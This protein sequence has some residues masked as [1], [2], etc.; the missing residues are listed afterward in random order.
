V[1]YSHTSRNAEAVGE[2]EAAFEEDRTN[3]ETQLLLGESLLRERR[4]QEA[5]ITLQRSAAAHPTVAVY[6]HLAKAYRGL[7]DAEGVRMAIAS[8]HAFQQA[9]AVD[10]KIEVLRGAAEHAVAERRY[11]EAVKAY[12]S[13]V[14]LRPGDSDLLYHEALAK[15]QM[16]DREEELQLLREV[17]VRSP[18]MAGALCEVGILEGMKG[19]TVAAKGH[20]REALSID[21]QRADALSNLAVLM[22]QSGD[23]DSAEAMLT[24]AIESSPRYATAYRNLGLVY[25]TEGRAADAE[26]ALRKSVAIDASDAANE[27]ALGQFCL[28]QKNAASAVAAFRAAV[29]LQPNDVPGRLLLARTLLA[30]GDV[31]GA[32]EEIHHALRLSPAAPEAVA[33]Q[34]ALCARPGLSAASVA[35]CREVGRPFHSFQRSPAKDPTK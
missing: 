24:N 31:Q 26:A 13:A 34:R 4:F 16:G 7:G 19:E 6:F 3:A 5:S 15:G 8:L 2:F 29:A 23:L 12:A 33:L 20:L 25:A 1:I 32:L 17:L 35:V 30:Q 9:Q 28:S 22:A 18:K 21:P 11:D 27:V 10:T 14:A